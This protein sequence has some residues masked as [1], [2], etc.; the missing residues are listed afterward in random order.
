[1]CYNMGIL[2][3]Y[4]DLINTSFSKWIKVEDKQSKWTIEDFPYNTGVDEDIT[5]PHCWKCVTVNKCWFKNEENKK[6]QVIRGNPSYNLA[7][8]FWRSIKMFTFLASV[9]TSTSALHFG[10]L[11]CACPCR[12][13]SL[14]LHL[15]QRTCSRISIAL[16]LHL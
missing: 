10:H 6:R 2:D 12:S 5:K 13:I 15:G 16:C 4:K 1:M 11:I 7:L 8:Y 9:S 3:S 14:L